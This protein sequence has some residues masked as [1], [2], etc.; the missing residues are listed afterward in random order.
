MAQIDLNLAFGNIAL[1]F[2]G[3]GNQFADNGR[4]FAYLGMPLGIIN[5]DVGFAFAFEDPDKAS[6]DKS[7]NPITAGIGLKA[8]ISDLFGI[9]LRTWAA[10]GGKDA[11]GDAT[12]FILTA[13]L[14]PYLTLSDSLRVFFT[15]GMAMAAPSE[16]DSTLGFHINPYI[17]VGQEWGPKFLAGFKLSNDGVK[18]ADDKTV[19]NWAF[20]IGIQSSF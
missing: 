5:L 6:G 19:T 2:D 14:N 10:F 4:V 15:L 11:A 16:G 18:D 12:P 3:R 13:D 9:K 17:E 7:A 20:A 1:T 8:G